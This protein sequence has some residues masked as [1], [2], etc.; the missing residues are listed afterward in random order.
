MSWEEQIQNSMEITTGDGKVYKP[1]HVGVVKEIEY[2]IAEFEFPD[3]V[4][5]RVE[6][7]TPKGTRHELEIIFQGAD[8]IDQAR[9]FE[10]SNIDKREWTINHPIH[11]ILKVQPIRLKFDYNGLNT[12]R[13]TGQVVET[14]IDDFP[15][16]SLDPVNESNSKLNAASDNY[17][18]AF[19]NVSLE[20]SDVDILSG[21]VDST[22]A[23]AADQIPSGDQA[24]EYFNLFKAANSSLNDALSEPVE[25]ISAVKGYLLYP[26]LLTLSVK[27]KLNLLRAQFNLI[28][29]TS[30]S[31]NES[32]IYENNAGIIIQ[33]MIYSAVNADASIDYQNAPDV[34]EVLDQLNLNYTE[35]IENLNLNQ[36]DTGSETES[37]LPDPVSVSSLQ[38]AF[39]YAVSQLF[40]IAL[41]S[42]QQRSVI[43]NY[44]TNIIELAHRFY[45]L[46]PDDSTIDEIIETNMLSMDELIQVPANK[47]IIYFV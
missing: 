30:S 31:P 24:N 35:Y 39:N 43:L 45:G 1:L 23:A 37:Y 27:T 33:A 5:T 3:V 47:E 15:K 46:L 44:D 8:N 32:L 9:E 16:T 20:S 21:N 28:N 40:N 42:R 29:P 41:R 10:F 14:I 18:A 22:Y 13:I 12:C 38:S 34:F 25:A 19:E 17:V 2:N 26:S 6:R 4:G 11:G 36:T 7:G